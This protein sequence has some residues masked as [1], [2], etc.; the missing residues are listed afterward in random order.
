M[1][2]KIY[3]AA[4]VRSYNQYVSEIVWLVNFLQ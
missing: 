3:I 4:C 1:V 2:T